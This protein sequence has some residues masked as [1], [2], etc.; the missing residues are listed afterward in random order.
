[1]RMNIRPNSKLIF[2]KIS[3]C[4][5]VLSVILLSFNSPPTSQ[6]SESESIDTDME[7]FILEIPNSVGEGFEPHILVGPGIDGNE[8]LYID[9][10]TGLGSQLS[11]NLWISKD[12]GLTWEF[13][14]TGRPPIN[15]GGSGDSYRQAVAPDWSYSWR[16]ANV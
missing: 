6:A 11:G 8:W 7:F 10:P 1:M 12:G 16:R 14:E 15:Y 13:K 2:K 3:V 4:I 9:S 5:I